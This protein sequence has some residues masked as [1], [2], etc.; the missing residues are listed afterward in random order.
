MT[1][2]SFINT[3]KAQFVLLE[4][5]EVFDENTHFKKLKAWDSMTALLVISTI[6]DEYNVSVSGDDM[7]DIN[8]VGELYDFVIR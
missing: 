4:T 3:I 1:Q 8:T 6:F 7:V 2:E 5:N